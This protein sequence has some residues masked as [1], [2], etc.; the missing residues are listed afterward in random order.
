MGKED[1]EDAQAN[2]TQN[3][4]NQLLEENFFNLKKKMPINTRS[5][6]N[7]RQTEPERKFL[8]TQN[9]QNAE[10]KEQNECFKSSKGE[11]PS[12][13]Q[14]HT[15]ENFALLLNGEDKKDEPGQMC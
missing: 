11:R 2:A 8:P 4:F 6:Q 5:T 14:R 13:I 1:G 12:D 9:H 3:T 7:T 15:Y 10:S